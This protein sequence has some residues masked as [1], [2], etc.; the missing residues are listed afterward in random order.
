MSEVLIKLPCFVNFQHMWSLLNLNN[1]SDKFRKCVWTSQN[2]P[3][4]QP[5]TWTCMRKP[6]HIE[7][8]IN[9]ANGASKLQ[10]EGSSVS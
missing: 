5:H 6:T 9:G 2:E 8:Q 3:F 1:C 7:Q 4:L 10:Q